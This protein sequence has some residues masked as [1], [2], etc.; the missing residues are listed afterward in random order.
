MFHKNLEDYLQDGLDFSHRFAIER[1]ARECFSCR[2]DLAGAIELRRMALD[3]KQVKAPADF[4][5]ALL[6]K[7]GRCK[8]HSR[9]SVFRRIWF[10]GPDWLSWKKLMIA[11]SSLAVLVL[12]II[13][14]SHWKAMNS[15]LPPPI[16]V[17]H[18]DKEVKEKAEASIELPRAVAN[19]LKSFSMPSIRNT[20]KPVP[21]SLMGEL[22]NS[23][24][25]A[26][27]YF[28]V[29][30][31]GSDVRPEPVRMLPKKIRLQYIPA[32][33]EYFLYYVSH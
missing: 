18:P 23:G 19:K 15:V 28:R 2:K 33:E 29:V 13:T 27:D 20:P 6:D 25:P 21:V 31:A 3:I 24:V 10:Y 16:A 9:L 17:N 4:E 7:I 30:V 12:G 11:S 8:A 5:I 22:D 14:A 32:S 1:H 26:P